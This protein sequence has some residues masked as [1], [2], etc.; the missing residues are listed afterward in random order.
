MSL[1]AEKNGLSWSGRESNRVFL[2]LGGGKFSDISGL[3][4]AE[5]LSDSRACARLDWDGDGRE[6]LVLRN[7]NAPRLRL[8]LNRWP[9]PGNW[10][11]FD[12]VGTQCNRDAIGA[13]VFVEAGAL[14][15]RGSVRAGEGF[16]SASSKRVHLGVG[17]ETVAQRVRVRWPGGAVEE[18]EDLAS[19]Q[20]WRIVQGSGRAVPVEAVRAEALLASVPEPARPATASPTRIPLIASLPLA[21][22]PIPAWNDP[23]RTVADLAGG[24]VLINFWSSTCASC[25]DEF[26][27]FKKRKMP[28]ERSGLRI[29]PLL[30]EETDAIAEARA[31]LS[32]Y[33][34][35]AL[36]GKL[37]ERAKAAF[38]L[39]FNETVWDSEDLPLPCSLLLD[40]RGQLRVIYLGPV[41]FRELSQDLQALASLPEDAIQDPWLCGGRVLIPRLRNLDKLSARFAELGLHEAANLYKKRQSEIAALIQR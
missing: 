8:M 4:G 39:V 30:V 21:P 10:L 37:D 27:L 25:L 32:A 26:D 17:A 6:D 7:R 24:P 9:R 13:H 1:L 11:Q 15:L 29:V 36:G 23:Q 18:F 35:D 19:N 34:L 16:L 14:R 28:L 12:L 5:W 3:T 22:L 38:G 31:I 2:N 41:K 33:G 40:R 20:R